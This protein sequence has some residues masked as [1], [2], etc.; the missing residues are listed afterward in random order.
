MQII[1]HEEPK[2]ERPTFLC[3]E[4]LHPKLDNNPLLKNMNK[5]FS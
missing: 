4:V 5:T 3:D 1:E 2:L